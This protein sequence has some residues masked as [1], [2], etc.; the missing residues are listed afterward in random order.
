M[1]EQI[2]IKYKEETLLKSEMTEREKA[3]WADGYKQGVEE[4]V[5]SYVRFYAGLVIG[6]VLCL[7]I[8][9]A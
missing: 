2:V 5:N 8:S 3:I 1:N 4:K 6:A 9:N 7:L